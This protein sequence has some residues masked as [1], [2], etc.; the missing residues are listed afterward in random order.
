MPKP[1]LPHLPFGNTMT[2]QAP[3][4]VMR[5]AAYQ[6]ALQNVAKR[7][8]L[9]QLANK[10]AASKADIKSHE[11]DTTSDD[12]VSHLASDDEDDDD[13]DD[14]ARKHSSRSP[15]FSHSDMGQHSYEADDLSKNIRKKKTRTVFSRN[16]VR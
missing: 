13:E 9:R 12:D 16:Q 2:S 11:D 3:A 4:D 6:V 5:S 14:E 7:E 10:A 8:E 1:L 15:G